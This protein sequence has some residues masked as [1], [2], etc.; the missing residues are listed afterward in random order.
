MKKRFLA[1]I[2]ATLFL[3]SCSKEG[4]EYSGLNE[5]EVL[6]INI[7]GLSNRDAMDIAGNMKKITI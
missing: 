2:L 4:Q 6:D 3:L 7:D 5:F 1:I